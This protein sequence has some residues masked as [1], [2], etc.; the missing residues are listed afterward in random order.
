MCN[1]QDNGYPEPGSVLACLRTH[2]K[3]LTEAC[4]A[5][6]FRTMEQAADDFKLDAALNEK[7]SPDAEALCADVEEGEGRIQ[8]C[9]R[10]RKASLSWDCQEELFRQEVEDAGD[11]RLNVELLILAVTFLKKL[12]IFE[13]NKERM[14]QLKGLFAEG[15]TGCLAPLRSLQPCAPNQLLMW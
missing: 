8:A 12:S 6:V 4:D 11:F 13:E 15:D 3:D 5:Q 2:K 7:C 14:M 10:K 9:L 1:T